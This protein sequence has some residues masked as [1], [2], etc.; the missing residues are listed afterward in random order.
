MTRY[1]PGSDIVYQTT[2]TNN[3]AV[4]DPTTIAFQYKLGRW[5]NW[6][7]VTPVKVSTGLYTATVNPTYGGSLYWQWKTTGPNFVDEGYDYVT[8]SE[9][10]TYD[11]PI[12]NYDYGRFW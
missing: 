3:G 1:Y 8:P 4:A 10:N 7:S 5:G 9:F 12:T 2:I 11:A 6:T